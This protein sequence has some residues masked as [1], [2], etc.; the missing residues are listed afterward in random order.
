M[1]TNTNAHCVARRGP[2][3]QGSGL[4]SDW[5]FT[6]LL[7]PK[8]LHLHFFHICCLNSFYRDSRPLEVSFILTVLADLN[9]L[10]KQQTILNSLIALPFSYLFISCLEVLLYI[11]TVENILFYINTICLW[12]GEGLLAFLNNWILQR[13][14]NR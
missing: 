8:F 4:D 11:K 5:F 7:Q 6:W 3:Y 12:T 2:G 13:E 10:L 14:Y 9:F 1:C